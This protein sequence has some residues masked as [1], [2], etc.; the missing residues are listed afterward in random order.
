MPYF[1]YTVQTRARPFEDLL[2]EKDS[3]NYIGCTI[4]QHRRD[5]V[6]VRYFIF[7]SKEIVLHRLPILRKLH[8]GVQ[9][10]IVSKD[11][12][13]ATHGKAPIIMYRDFYA[14]LHD[15]FFI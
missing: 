9:L 2:L 13:S 4:F 7:D 10:Q 14:F 8:R 6:T 15:N 1:L 5:D 3:P 11:T 12:R